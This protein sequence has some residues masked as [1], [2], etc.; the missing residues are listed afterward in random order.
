[1]ELVNRIAQR[2]LSMANEELRLAMEAEAESGE[3]MDSMQ[4]EYW[5]GYTEALEF[6]LRESEGK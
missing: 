6:I 4:R 1:M 5:V 3:A 2:E